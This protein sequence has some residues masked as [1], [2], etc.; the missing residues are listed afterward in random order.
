M[1]KLFLFCIVSLSILFLAVPKGVASEL[2][3]SVAPVIPENQKDKNKSYFDLKME[4]GKGQELTVTLK[5]GT[6]NK[7]TINTTINRATTNLN[8]VVEYGSAKN[9]KDSS[10]VYNI[11]DFIEIKEP[12][13]EIPAHSEKQLILNLKGIPEKFEGVLAGGLTFKEKQATEKTKDEEKQGLAIQNE[14]AYVV[15]IVLHGEKETIPS[16]I[17]LIGAEAA[18]V[19]ARNA[20]NATLQNPKAKY[21]NKLSVDAVVTKK[22]S[23]DV[24]YSSKKENMQMAPNSHFDYPISLEGEALKPGNYTVTMK[25]NSY[26]DHW[27]VT[28]DFSINKEQADAFNKNDVSIKEDSTWVYLV[29][30]LSLLLLI[31]AIVVIIVLQKKKKKKERIRQEKLRRRKMAMQR[32]KRA[33]KNSLNKKVKKD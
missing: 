11:E 28:K 33:E 21:L 16:E 13:V 1:K 20:I 17:K 12:E 2:N 3:F 30:G 7:V 15:G 6:D 24:L 26:D 10:L 9:Q 23:Q 32:K 29:I 8:G 27:E 14:Y 19:N 22:G 25:I 18:Q 31:V 4:S 5:N